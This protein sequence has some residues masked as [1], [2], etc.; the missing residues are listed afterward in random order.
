MLC[1]LLSPSSGNA[2]MRQYCDQ[3]QQMLLVTACQPCAG[4]KCSFHC[5][6]GV[7]AQPASNQFV[8]VQSSLCGHSLP[9]AYM[10]SMPDICHAVGFSSS[11]QSSSACQAMVQHTSVMFASLQF[12]SDELQAAYRTCCCTL[13]PMSPVTCQET[14]QVSIPGWTTT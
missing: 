2:V 6:Q 10:C 12:I 3:C 8:S 9:S 14:S 5:E 1:K 13:L 7:A 11:W 4:T